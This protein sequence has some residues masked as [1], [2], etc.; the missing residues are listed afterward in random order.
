MTYVHCVCV[1]STWFENS[2]RYWCRDNISNVWIFQLL[3]APV[4]LCNLYF[5]TG[6]VRK[7]S[8]VCPISPHKEVTWVHSVVYNMIV[9]FKYFDFKTS[10][11]SASSVHIYIFKYRDQCRCPAISFRRQRSDYVNRFPPPS[12]SP[13]QSFGTKTRPY[14]QV[15]RPVLISFWK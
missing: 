1:F 4:P 14:A 13:G 10:R 15:D 2:T 3:F 6:F 7:S 8:E 9:L 11:E 5:P 12:R